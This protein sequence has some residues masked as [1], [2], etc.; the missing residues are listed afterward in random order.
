MPG[1][2]AFVQGVLAEDGIRGKKKHPSMDEFMGQTLGGAG[3]DAAPA[4]SNIAPPSEM[5]YNPQTDIANRPLELPE[6]MP[7][8]PTFRQPG[9]LERAA[10]GAAMLG[11]DIVGGLRQGAAGVVN[12][13]KPSTMETEHLAWLRDLPE[14]ALQEA[15]RSGQIPWQDTR[16]AL[17]PP[18]MRREA[19]NRAIQFRNAIAEGVGS[20]ADAISPDPSPE[21]A[22]RQYVPSAPQDPVRQA[23]QGIAGAVPGAAAM[24]GASAMGAPSPAIIAANAVAAQNAANEAVYNARMAGGAEH[25]EAYQ[26][27]T[28]ASQV[29]QAATNL[30]TTLAML[31]AGRV[32]P[33]ALGGNMS[34]YVTQGLRTAAQMGA[35]AA[36][37]A[38][39][40]AIQDVR[41][42]QDVDLSAAGA[43][44]L[45]GLLQAGLFGLYNT[46][47]DWKTLQGL[48]GT[49]R[50]INETVRKINTAMEDLGLPKVNRQ[51][52][53]NDA[54][55]M[56][57][58]SMRAGLLTPDRVFEALTK[59]GF[60]PAE[61]GA[62]VRRGAPAQQGA[63]ALHGAA[64]PEQG[65]VPPVPA[66][67]GQG[68]GGAAYAQQAM[69][70][71]APAGQLEQVLSALQG[72]GGR[73][74]A[75]PI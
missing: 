30:A 52:G 11:T 57:S 60:D 39:N 49:H 42:G 18:D 58:N 75:L 19:L 12:W 16:Y 8:A 29:P 66:P 21:K 33:M 64:L 50:Q 51:Y 36:G 70:A 53:V 25:P 65:G 31:G 44:G 9:I 54:S 22:A 71:P 46:A 35:A 2:D 7:G 61:V 74:P 67:T 56:L 15:L 45:Q 37:D 73:M 47:L 20:V 48:Q 68:G 23:V 28:G 32:L 69:P 6:G 17:L 55:S 63:L 3:A 24:I 1:L 26:A 4:L 41:S 10:R 62:L 43:A 72:V 27:A 14:D 59:A 13:A 40:S 34:P 38:A 5:V